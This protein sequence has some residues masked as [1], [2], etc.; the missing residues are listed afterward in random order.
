[1]VFLRRF[2]LH[3]LVDPAA[4]FGIV[5][6]VDLDADSA[7]VNGAGFAGVFAL[8]LQFG[9]F[10]GTEEAERIEIALEVSPL[11]VGVE[12]ALALWVRAVDDCR[13]GAAVGS[14]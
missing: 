13:S 7:G 11:A 8:A 3:L 4:A 5:D 1:M 9:S 2:G 14:L 6:M 10:A 12:D